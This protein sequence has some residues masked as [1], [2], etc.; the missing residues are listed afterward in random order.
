MGINKFRKHQL[1]L[2]EE[3]SM[4]PSYQFYDA[5]FV[6]SGE[7]HGVADILVDYNSDYLLD[8]GVNVPGGTTTFWINTDGDNNYDTIALDYN[9]DGVIDA[10]YWDTNHDLLPDF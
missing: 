2:L 1:P 5:A 3:N 9:R 6:S 7:D 10:A 4:R 8:H